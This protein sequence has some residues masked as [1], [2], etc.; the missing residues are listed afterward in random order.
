[1]EDDLGVRIVSE[2]YEVWHDLDAMSDVIADVVG[3]LGLEDAPVALTTTAE[4]V[5]VFASKR[6][7]VL[8]VLDAA[9][10]ALPERRLRVMTT[11]GELVSSDAARAEPLPCAA[12]NWMA[13]ASWSRAPARR[14]PG[15]LRG[16]TTD[17]IPI[18]G[19][20]SS[21]RPDGRR[22]ATLRRTGLHRRAADQRRRHALA[23][24]DRWP[25]VPGDL[26]AVRDQ[27]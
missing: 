2:P 8:Y 6:E 21:P 1:M 24:A 23:R 11:G 7:G 19:A 13:T 9:C 20:G 26:G 14:D 16:T 5:D 27:R 4:L 18:A 22:A 25:A 3:R 10:R 12:A 17:V 15:G